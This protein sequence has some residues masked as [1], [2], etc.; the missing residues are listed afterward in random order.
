ML[1]LDNE[2]NNIDAL[3]ELKEFAYSYWEQ[4]L[5]TDTEHCDIEAILDEKLSKL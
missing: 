4:K 1:V 5:L 3:L 2:F